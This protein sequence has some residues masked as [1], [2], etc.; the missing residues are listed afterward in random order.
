MTNDK[1]PREWLINQVINP[2]DIQFSCISAR[3]KTKQFCDAY[4]SLAQNLKETETKLL[5]TKELSSKLVEENEWLKAEV[6]RL[7]DTPGGKRLYLTF[8]ELAREREITAMLREAVEFY[9]NPPEKDAPNVR[10]EFGC[11]CCVGITDADGNIQE[12]NSALQ[13]LT[14][15]EAIAREAEMRKGEE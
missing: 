11:G 9:A 6:E 12:Y 7:K 14:A 13:G 3:E 1:L 4:D 10:C 15:R 2:T 8:N 5:N